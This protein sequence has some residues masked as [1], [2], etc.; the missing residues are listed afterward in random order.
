MKVLLLHPPGNYKK[1][2]DAV[3]NLGLGYIAAVLR[4]D[5]HEVEILDANARCMKVGE[6]VREIL[7]RDFDCL[8]ITAINE[9]KKH[10]ISVVRAVR[11]KRK[12]ALIVVGGY[13][14]TLETEQFLAECPEVDFVVRG[15]GEIS[16]PDVFGRIER[17]E[18]WQD[19]P[20][21]A[22]R[23]EGVVVMNPMP[24]L[25]QNLDSLPFPA[26]DSLRD[27]PTLTQTA[28]AGSR[29]C[30]HNC[31][32]CSISAF[33]GLSGTSAPRFRSPESIVDEMES[34]VASTGRTMFSFADDDFI[35]PGEKCRNRAIQIADQIK[36]RNLNINFSIE[37]RA[38]EVDEDLLKLLKEAGLSGL[39]LGIESGVQRQLDTFNKGTTVEQNKRAIEIVQRLDLRLSSGLII[40]DPY[41]TMDDLM[42]T[43]K[44]IRETGPYENSAIESTVLLYRG[45]PLAERA[46]ADGLLIE[47]G[48]ELGYRF[49]DRSMAPLWRALDTFIKCS[50][51][52]KRLRERGRR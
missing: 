8:G 46:R 41:T 7:T 11:E 20:G 12:D 27:I 14:A 17:G 18:K 51:F 16:A 2:S 52:V 28:I 29:G 23:S 9:F 30:Y 33:Y 49:K 43:L 34:I 1:L 42:E 39:F 40:F 10:V 47:K 13:T 5:G 6:A 48:M 45:T 50:Q 21:I 31:S 4:R 3:E 25:I 22:Y 35:G 19:T 37:C 44:F 26:R 38:D 32:F 15:E 36:A 24:P